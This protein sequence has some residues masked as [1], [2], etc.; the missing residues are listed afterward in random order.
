[1]R[2]KNQ[3]YIPQA[4]LRSF[5]NDGKTIWVYDKYTQTINKQNIKGT[6]SIK[7]FYQSRRHTQPLDT[8]PVTSLEGTGIKIIKKIDNNENITPEEGGQLL[9]FI[10]LQYLRTPA[11]KNRSE[12]SFQSFWNEL[13]KFYR[14]SGF[15]N[16]RIEKIAK[17]Y[18]DEQK[19]EGVTPQQFLKN[20]D[21]ITPPNEF[22]VDALVSSGF[23]IAEILSKQKWELLFSKPN[24]WIT[25][26]DPFSVFGKEDGTLFPPLVPETEKIIPLSKS[27]LLVISGD[28][29][30]IEMKLMHPWSVEVI[31]LATASKAARYVYSGNKELLEDIN[32]N[33]SLFEKNPESFTEKIPKDFND[34][35]K[36]GPHTLK[37]G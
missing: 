32:K 14:E 13:R 9:N 26:D 24:S 31:N 3:H 36:N 25:S 29:F 5:S 6:G 30:K 1:M 12:V 8:P 10:A 11:A 20:N 19:I 2:T 34:W 4:Y 7:H 37:Q 35:S 33:L 22:F 18:I 23:N 21:S 17:S 15:Q 27:S 28:G 16:Q